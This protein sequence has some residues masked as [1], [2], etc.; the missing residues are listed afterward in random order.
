MTDGELVFRNESQSGRTMKA[1]RKA[2]ENDEEIAARVKLFLYRVTEE[3][4]DLEQDPCCLNNLLAAGDGAA[5]PRRSAMTKA[6][7]HWMKDTGDP[8]R[9]L[10]EKQVEL[11]L[12]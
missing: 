12:D 5:E 1:M 7:W 2:A 9:A 8:D 11:A 10:F 4:Y 3:L 6:L